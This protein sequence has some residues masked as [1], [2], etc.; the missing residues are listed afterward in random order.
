MAKIIFYSL[1]IV[2]T[3]SLLVMGIYRSPFFNFGESSAAAFGITPPYIENFSIL[4]GDSF[5]RGITLVRS[6]SEKD[7]Y[8]KVKIKSDGFS[9]WINL[10]EKILFPAGHTRLPIVIDFDV[11]ASV[12]AGDYSGWL[13]FSQIIRL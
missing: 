12:S 1:F 9:D 13:W 11:P 7:T 4:P 5:K 6:V 2:S 10:G 3:A 8:I